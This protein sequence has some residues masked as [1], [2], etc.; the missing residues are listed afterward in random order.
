LSVL[1]IFGPTA[2][3]KSAV[4]RE[5]AAQVGGEVVSADAMQVYQGLPIL[6][7][8]DDPPPRLAAI[9]PL[10]HEASVAEYQLLAHASVD[11]L[12]ASGRTPVIAGGTGLY[13]RA[14]LSALE[15]PPAPSRE[16]RERWQARYDEEG[17]EPMHD[18]L[19][20]VDPAAAARIH[21]NDRRRVVRALELAEVGESLA[22]DGLW[23]SDTRH[24]TLVF[25]LDVQ[26]EE[27]S[28]RIEERSRT[29]FERGVEAEVARALE[30]PLSYTAEQAIGL[31]EL[32]ELRRDE[33]LERLIVRTRRYA[34]YQR[35]WMRRMPD[36]VTVNADRPPGETA[37]E[38]LEMARAREHL[39]RLPGA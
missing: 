2:S 33:A 39:P 13:L 1:A 32:A 12:L 11:E 34:A 26:P 28:R 5:V 6:T 16:A 17:A 18:L 37:D 30:R 29:M 27:L 20:E 8:Q 25:G 19:A 35:K 10:H 22:D 3:G 24:P 36:L 7:N 21:P 14:A 4:A 31:R 38:I 15:I 9:W 23:G